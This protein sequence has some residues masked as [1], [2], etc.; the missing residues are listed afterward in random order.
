MS[1]SQASQLEG[2]FGTSDLLQILMIKDKEAYL[3]APQDVFTGTVI[4]T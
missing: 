1:N 3:N 2:Y 4:M